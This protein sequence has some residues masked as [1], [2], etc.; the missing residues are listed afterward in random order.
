VEWLKV[1]ALSSKPSTKKKKEE[2]RKEGEK[3]EEGR[4][5][6][7]RRGRGGFGLHSP[8]VYLRSSPS[9]AGD[10]ERLPVLSAAP[11]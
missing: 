11:S 9:L 4:G 3:G 1:S 6:R 10:V 7:E 5:R 2:E 8:C